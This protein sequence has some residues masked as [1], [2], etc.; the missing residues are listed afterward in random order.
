MQHTTLAAALLAALSANALANT[1]ALL[2]PA[3]FTLDE[4]VVTATRIPTP[5]REVLTDITVLTAHQILQSG[6]TSLA[7]LLATVPGVEVTVNG[8]LGGNQN[9]R[10]RGSS[11]NH[12]LV[13]IDGQRLG[14]ATT[15]ATA[16]E[17]LP[18]H[19]I[20]RVE[21][22]RAPASNLYGMDAVGGVMQV[23]TK[24][25]GSG[26]SVEAGIGAY[27][28]RK[29][30]ADIVTRQ[31]SWRMALS[32]GHAENDG[33]SSASP[34]ARWG[35]YDPDRDAYRNN[36]GKVGFG[37]AWRDG[38]LS[39]DV[40]H[41][42]ARTEFDDANPGRDYSDQILASR[43]LRLKQSWGP[44]IQSTLH[45][46]SSEDTLATMSGNSSR[47]KTSQQQMSLE[48]VLRL[49][50]GDLL[51]GAEH[52]RQE[53]ESTSNFTQAAR[54]VKSLF[55]GYGMKMDLHT[56]QF[57]LRHDDNSQFGSKT[58]GGLGY[59]YQLRPGLRVLM[60]G[61]TAFK[62]PTF[63]DL[64]FPFT[65][66]GGG[67]SYAGNPNLKSERARNLEVGIALN[68][69]TREIR[70]TLYRQRV[71]D[72]ILASSGVAAD[73]PVNVGSAE[74]DGLEM[75]VRKQS[76]PLALELGMTWQNAINA[77]TRKDLT[78]R[79]NQFGYLKSTL[80][81]GRTVW[82]AEVRFE[83]SRF[84]DTDNTRKVSGYGVLNLSMTHE[85]ARDWQLRM[86]MDNALD[87]AYEQV[88]GFNTPSRSVFAT[89]RYAPK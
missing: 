78:Y 2:P 81:Q 37:Y 88:Y 14:S 13:L 32:L 10:V 18:L 77:E 86:R 73:A 27:G 51:L 57:N 42:D 74:I 28:Y 33:F 79:A 9:V 40:M 62:A 55:A 89:L 87:K 59:G 39:V 54:E 36:S 26:A 12:F 21:L 19:A 11:A 60:T 29:T 70:A 75:F 53:V 25:A 64:Y 61:A 68:D 20:E 45:L 66:F 31:G 1:Q 84:D 52:L 69:A 83:G 41:V 47:F 17:H 49:G 63:N 72:L 58:T 7:E 38:D 34:R 46:G 48:N 50:R 8:G 15:G 23:F 35:A 76:G 43:S 4:I 24:Q 30:S 44:G 71:S 16:L 22:V 85:L 82:A 67:W 3:E 65:D 5:A 6:A 56:M 80:Q